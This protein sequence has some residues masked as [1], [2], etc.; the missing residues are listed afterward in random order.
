MSLK[1]FKSRIDVAEG[2]VILLEEPDRLSAWIIKLGDKVS[3]SGNS[4]T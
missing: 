2:D 3:A 1:C 4:Q